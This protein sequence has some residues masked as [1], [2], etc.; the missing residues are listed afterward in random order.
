M[1]IRWRLTLWFSLIL[2]GILVLSGVVLHFTLQTS[3]INAVDDNLRLYSAQVHST[4]HILG[5]P[6]TPDYNAIHSQL[7]LI[8]EFASPGIYLQILDKGGK[9]AVKSENLGQQELPVDPFLINTGL[10][11]SAGIAS[12]AAGSGTQVRIMVSPLY[13]GDQTLVLE[14]AQSLQPIETALSQVNYAILASILVALILASVSGSF[15]VR[16]A[17][18]PVSRI[19]RTAES[20]ETGKDLTRR[21]GYE[22]P[23]DE[24]GQLAATFDRMIGELYSTFESQKRFVADASHDL[25]SPLTVIRCNLDL[26]KRNLSEGDRRE[27]LRAIEAEADRMSRIVND[28]LLLAEIDSGQT[29]AKERVSL[30]NVLLEEYER[31]VKLTRSHRISIVHQ[32][33]VTV[34]GN[35]LRLKQM[36]GNLLDNAIKYTPDGGTISL[37][38]YRD[39]QWARI[40]VSDTG[41]GISPEHLPHMFDRFYRDDQARSRTTG[42][43]GLGL[44]IVKSI[45]EQH[46]GK[47][48]VTSEPG[49]G[50]TFS[51]WL[52]L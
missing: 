12:V 16:R 32:E 46:G 21:V 13:V 15:I 50:S 30:R 3:L 22:G 14:V 11:G 8:N 41:I 2:C 27:S 47:V 6:Q 38:L 24:I 43:T 35:K 19:T 40:D 7:P 28:L 9:V 49:K 34:E 31:A 10:N 51:V 20:I 5:S 18:W 1:P 26:M 29:E 33:D 36:L 52:K 17:L 39:S 37:S 42:G 25:R 44:A 48:A 23:A 4:F 45:A